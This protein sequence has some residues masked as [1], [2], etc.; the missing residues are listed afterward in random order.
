[1]VSLLVEIYYLQVFKTLQLLT[2]CLWNQMSSKFH[3][4]LTT[5]R[6]AKTEISYSSFVKQIDSF[7]NE[8]HME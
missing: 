5:V 1:M 2:M 8:D 4:G 7:I 3:S 6:S